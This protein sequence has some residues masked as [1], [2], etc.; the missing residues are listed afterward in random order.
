M[1][2]QIIALAVL[3]ISVLG[4]SAQESVTDNKSSFGLKGGYNLASVK[5]DSDSETGQRHGFNVGFYG[6]SFEVMLLLCK[7]SFNTHNKVMRLKIT[8]PHLLKK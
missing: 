6:E 2:K 3:L 7:L 4:V 5:F 1:K 8:T